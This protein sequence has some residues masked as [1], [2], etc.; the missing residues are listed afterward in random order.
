MISPG[1]YRAVSHPPAEQSFELELLDASGSVLTAQ[2]VPDPR[3]IFAEMAAPGQT[4]VLPAADDRSFS[5]RLPW[6]SE[7][8]HLRVRDGAGTLLLDAPITDLF[9]RRARERY[10]EVLAEISAQEKL[11]RRSIHQAPARIENSVEIPELY[12]LEARDR[13][14]RNLETARLAASRAVAPPD[15]GPS[16]V[17]VS[18]RVVDISGQPV[19]KAGVVVLDASTGLALGGADTTA[20]GRANLNI[21]DVRAQLYVFPPFI[22]AGAVPIYARKI[23]EI[24]L[25]TSPSLD[26]TLE[27]GVL[28]TGQVTRGAD[29][30]GSNFSVTAVDASTNRSIEY[31]RTDVN[32]FFKLRVPPGQYRFYVGPRPG[33]GLLVSDARDIGGD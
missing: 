14:A 8:R 7:A 20:D 26:I 1:R 13:S 27:P 19:T 12:E 21:A 4:H 18:V 33:Y 22:A 3:Q 25:K 23:V 5:L 15:S 29:V 9:V 24:D 31:A 11:A 10:K 30:P 2:H 6:I 17:A 28:V 16:Y 32:G